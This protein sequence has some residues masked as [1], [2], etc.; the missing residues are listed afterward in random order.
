MYTGFTE[1]DV[2]SETVGPP[3]RRPAHVSNA[4]RTESELEGVLTALR[5]A[6][7]AG[8]KLTCQWTKQY[9][10]LAPTLRGEVLVSVAVHRIEC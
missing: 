6:Y 2:I 3:Y 1:V 7:E 8:V 10:P 5:A 9:Q 4:G